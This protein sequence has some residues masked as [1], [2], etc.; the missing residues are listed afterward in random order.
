MTKTL[1]LQVKQNFVPA[2]R[3]HGGFIQQSFASLSR[4]VQWT[5]APKKFLQLRLSSLE[6]IVWQIWM[7]TRPSLSSVPFTISALTA[8][9]EMYPRY[10]ST[11]GAKDQMKSKEG[12]AS[13]PRES[14]LS[15][16]HI[17]TM[18][19]HQNNFRCFTHTSRHLGQLHFMRRS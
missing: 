16:P 11:E 7:L 15:S 13:V 18:L 5:G 14:A 10:E 3:P 9:D 1:C 19:N 12:M 6:I 2:Q 8:A 17:L 4:Q